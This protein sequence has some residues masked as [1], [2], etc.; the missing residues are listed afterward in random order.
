MIEYT[1]GS[2][3][4]RGL[5]LSDRLY[6]A[7]SEELTKGA[8]D[9]AVRSEQGTVRFYRT[10]SSGLQKWIDGGDLNA[11][12]IAEQL[13]A[14]ERFWKQQKQDDYCPRI[15]GIVN[16]TPDSFSDG[17]KFFDPTHAISHAK[18]L[19]SDGA[20][21][22]DIGG[23]STRPG[24]DRVEVDEEINRVVPVI[25]G[26]Q[27]LGKV[28]SIDT[29]KSAVMASAIEAG[30]NLINDVTALEY[31]EGSINVALKSNLPV[32]LMHSSADPKVMQDNPTYDH[33]LFDVIDYLRD[34]KE[35]CLQVGIRTEN[36]I[37]DPGIG[38]G[39]TVEH[40]LTL[41]KGLRFFHGLGCDILLGLSRKAFIGKLDR[42]GPAEERVAGSLAGLL[43]GLKAGVQMYRVHDVAESR[44]AIAVWQGIAKQSLNV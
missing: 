11:A 4:L 9:I 29:R 28:I 38:F 7:P 26:C 21:I 20:D 37:L 15:M 27:G 33:V 32:C 5:S 19:I 14:L 23:E 30:A 6:L 16:V 3:F 42:I 24:A 35:A 34:R 13:E 8:V 17:G 36:I 39:K 2:A 31:D 12:R 40:N 41:L 1:E 18:Q 10:S 25:Q 22:L 43:Y 44:Q